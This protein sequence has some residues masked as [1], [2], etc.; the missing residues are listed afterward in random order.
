[1][2]RVLITGATSGLGYQLC[3]DYHNLGFEVVACGRSHEKLA[4]K[5]GA[6]HDVKALCFD[7]T[8]KESVTSAFTLL[9][10]P[11]DIWILNAGD[12]QYID[13]GDLSSDI[14]AH[15]IETNF[16]SVVYCLS[17][18]QL[19]AK[20]G[21]QIVVVG[22]IASEFTFPRAEGYG[23]SKAALQ[24]LV[25]SLAIDW[26]DKPVALSL[27]MPGFIDTPLTKKN[28]FSMPMMISPQ[29]A[30]QMLRDGIEKRKPVIYFPRVFGWI[31]RTLGVLPYSWQR[32]LMMLLLPKETV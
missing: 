4:E 21:T 16:M 11:P 18:I 27:A 28:T 14:I 23:A 3:L 15:N 13:N 29:K 1:M 2:S 17:Q 26:R 12:C 30:S 19:V 22:S 32:K 31:V 9:S 20:P 8:N 10:T 7:V 6:L 25:N 24:Y 5:F